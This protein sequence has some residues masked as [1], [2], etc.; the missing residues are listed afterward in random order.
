[1]PL[2]PVAGVTR[3]RALQMGKESTFKT[4]VAAT[5]RYPW[6]AVPAPNPN[7]TKTTADTGTL[8][9]A[10][11]PYR[12]GLDIPITMT[13]DELASNDA[14]TLISAGVMG[15]L[16]LVP[17]STSNS[18]TAT[19]AST[20]QDVFDTYTAEVYDDAT[21]DA[22]TFSGGVIDSMT[23]TYPQN[24][25]PIQVTANWLFSKVASYPAT[26]TAGL[27]VDTNPVPLYAGDTFWYV[28]DT[29]GAI[30]TSQLVSQI[31]GG[32]IT[33]SNNLDVKRF[34]NGSNSQVEIQNFGRGERVLDFSMTFAKATAAIAESVKWIAASP[35]ERFVEIRTT[36]SV[37]AAV[38][39]PHSLTWR[40]PGYWFT[41]NWEE[42]NT[43]TGFSLTGQQVYDPTLTYPF[44]V[45]S[46][47]AR[48]ALT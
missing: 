22:W 24:S 27:T 46:V 45:Q 26:P 2:T 12:L 3:L 36:S 10:V 21:A 37:A 41:R 35:S 8:D 5:R 15:G 33:L 39:V 43:N 31:Y 6:S 47:S 20:T 14:P 16:A 28:N 48:T 29:A 4:A 17:S 40:I 1:M 42:I 11:A 9:L 13:I 30:G 19:P 32:S 18:L 23:F 44:R 25:G 38:G 34:Q 7:W